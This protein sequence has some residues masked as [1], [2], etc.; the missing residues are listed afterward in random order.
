[1]GLWERAI[2]EER[3]DLAG[4]EADLRQLIT[5][6]RH[7]DARPDVASG[8]RWVAAT[9]EEIINKRVPVCNEW[10]DVDEP[11]F[12]RVEEA[13]NDLD[14]SEIPDHLLV[15]T[16]NLFRQMILQ[17]AGV[18]R[19][20]AIETIVTSGWSE[21]V[22]ETLGRLLRNET[23][24]SWLRIRVL[25][26]LGFLQ[27]PDYS[28]EEDLTNA[29]MHAH[30]NL[31]PVQGNPQ[32]AHITEMHASLFAVGDCFGVP[33]AEDRA[34][35]VRDNLREIL[36]DLATAE[37]DRA[38]I[39]G[40]AARAAAYLLVVTAQPRQDKDK[41][42]SQELLKQLSAH[43]DPVTSRLSKWALTFRF[44]DD[45]SVRPLLAAAEHGL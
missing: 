15:G 31:K 19:R 17:N 33:G 25:F 6:F 23:E 29:C 2:C 11:W 16:K 30:A 5:E 10:P 43:S 28:V 4:T 22:A 9:L 13:A 34:K 1:M 14:N 20:Q 26:A 38:L 32:R 41:D 21:P 42:I 3:P 8:L 40:P 36:T 39:L 45:G 7:P 27:R 12:Y 24:E 35:N 37:G 18:H 44:A